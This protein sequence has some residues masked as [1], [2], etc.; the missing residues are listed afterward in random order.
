MRENIPFLARQIFLSWFLAR[1]HL[2]TK[3][4]AHLLKRSATPDLNESIAKENE[5]LTKLS[6]FIHL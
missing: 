2:H 5:W 4:L 1:Q 3:N 6:K